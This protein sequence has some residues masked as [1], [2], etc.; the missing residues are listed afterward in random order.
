M[1]TAVTDQ[2]PTI[3]L[4]HTKDENGSNGPTSLWEMQIQRLN[5]ASMI[6]YRYKRKK[7]LKIYPFTDSTKINR[8][9]HYI[10]M[11]WTNFWQTTVHVQQNIFE[12]SLTEVGSPHIYASI[13]TF[14]TQIGQLFAPQ[15]VFEHFEELQN[16][17]HFPSMTTICLFSKIFQRLIVPRII[18][19]FGSKRCQKKRKDVD[20]QLQ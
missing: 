6:R 13:G 5:M 14:C 3:Q 9:G 19:Q 12:K 7:T 2:Q 18:D 10:R 4:K 17:R 8:P 1:C 15:W 11:Y 20:C 16:R